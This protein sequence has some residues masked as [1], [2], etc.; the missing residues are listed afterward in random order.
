MRT[1]RDTQHSWST[2]EVKNPWSQW[3]GLTHPFIPKLL[4]SL[5]TRDPK[6]KMGTWYKVQFHR[7]SHHFLQ[8][9]I[10]SSITQGLRQGRAAVPRTIPSSCGEASTA[11]TAACSMASSL[12]GLCIIFPLFP[13]NRGLFYPQTNLPFKYFL[14]NCISMQNSAHILQKK[15][16][17]RGFFR[18]RGRWG[19][20]ALPALSVYAGNW[21]ALGIFACCA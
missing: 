14:L 3:W 19:K 9:R 12:Q 7:I 16:Q 6:C 13:N 17:G 11:G 4:Y 20:Q 8:L 2:T 5:S 15:T 10:M 21:V 18:G 1:F